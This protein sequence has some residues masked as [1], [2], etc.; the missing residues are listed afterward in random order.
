MK[1]TSKLISLFL[2][3]VLLG[4][5]P[6]Y[7]ANS[8]GSGF[9]DVRES[10]YYADAVKWAKETGVTS[11]TSKTTFSPASNV[12]RAQ[13][14]SFL[15]RAAGSPEP[16]SR[17]SPFTDVADAGAYYYK[18]ILWASEKGITAGI[19]KTEYGV[20]NPVAYDQM[21]AFLARFVGADTGSGNWSAN[22]VNWA[23]NAGFTD[24]LTFT[25][26]GA[27]PRSDVVYFLWKQ[28][29]GA[30]GSSEQQ[31][32]KTEQ[33]QKGLSDEEGARVAIVNGFL[34]RSTQIDVS[35]YNVEPSAL[36]EIAEK[37]ANQNGTNPYKIASLSCGQKKGSQAQSL[38]VTYQAQTQAN[39]PTDQTDAE[40]RKLADA[41]VAKVVT[42][43]M[44]DYET[45]K[46]LHDWLVLNCKYDMR[47]YS[48]NMPDV[49]YTAYGP[50]KYGTSVCAGYAKAYEALL[51]SAGMEAE[52]VTGDTDRGGHAWNIVKVDGEWYHV[53]VTW[54]DP[55]PDREGYVRY[56]YFLKSDGA[57]DRHFDWDASH[58]CTS[59]K[60][61]SGERV[62]QEQQ[63]QQQQQAAKLAEEIVA[64]CM[65]A[66]KT[67]PYPTQAELQAYE[68]LS[69]DDFYFT[70]LFPEGKFDQNQVIYA[71]MK[72]MELLRK[73]LAQSYPECELE[74]I[75]LVYAN[76]KR[77]DVAAELKR[78]EALQKEQWEQE[79]LE[80]QQKR[81]EQKKLEEEKKREE[82]AKTQAR[83]AETEAFVQE[84]IRNAS[85]KHYNIKVPENYYGVS[86]V[87][88]KMRAADYRFDDYTSQDFSVSYYINT[89]M[90]AINNYKWAAEEEQRQEQERQEK[91][92]RED[93]IA[94]QILE[95]FWRILDDFVR[96]D[97]LTAEK[98]SSSDTYVDLKC[99][100][101]KLTTG[102]NRKLKEQLEQQI[103]VRYPTCRLGESTYGWFIVYRDD[104]MAEMRRREAALQE[105]QQK[106]EEEQKK[107]EEEQRRQEEEQKKPQE[108]QQSPQEG[109]QQISQ[110]ETQQ[111]ETQTETE[112]DAA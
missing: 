90:L 76:I 29:G 42:P 39:T 81:E 92:A 105:E 65:D 98:L 33:T 95:D 56:N 44:G 94:A 21:F 106:R 110:E 23:A 74:N 19:S 108:Q 67:M 10:D 93:A 91:D 87:C 18:P 60:Y 100:W 47:L 34:T 63:E 73:E 49:S 17:T 64:Y 66:M 1:K 103:P 71:R 80:Q 20:S 53:D 45:A 46:A 79:K 111:Q 61:D 102:V 51:K 41:V 82:E 68:G 43:G 9:T 4:A 22:A 31:S 62:R 14:M 88:Q 109:A 30:G 28:Y 97:P 25:A 69:R 104:V 15:W 52:Y 32:G 8:D 72:A 6:A 78:R 86:E 55:I 48:G 99:S 84:A 85:S 54:D 35:S 57:L 70:I 24:G 107:Q 83:L 12:T 27:C 38:Q 96:K 40:I 112:A 77:Q 58:A 2:A 101:E 50:L 26:K 36:V 75:G 5:V 89:R 16:S 3:V 13:A 7:A 37:I 11:G 59:T